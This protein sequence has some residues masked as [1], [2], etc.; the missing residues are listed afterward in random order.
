MEARLHA[1]QAHRTAGRIAGDVAHD[2]NNSLAIIAGSLDLLEHRIGAGPDGAASPLIPLIVRARN[3]VQRAA[4]ITG[5]LH[6]L[7]RLRPEPPRSSMIGALV[8]GSVPLLTC[9]IGRRARLQVAVPPDLPPVQVDPGRLR[10][11][12]VALCLNAREAMPDGGD[13]LLDLAV[14]EAVGGPFVRL[15]LVDSGIGMT[16]EVAARAT[17]AFFT[18]GAE[19][20]IGL[21]LTEVA[22]FV[23]ECGGRVEIDTS[24]GTG[25]TVSLL[26]PCTEATEQPRA[27]DAT[28]DQGQR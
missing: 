2:F 22:A 15:R 27:G 5:G 4:D 21:G 6:A 9:V 19:E 1:T 13:L 3:A 16:P 18:T 28:P 8:T 10:A 11:A 25:T 14:D 20:A 12:L 17:E 7:S 24:P 26:F 23:H